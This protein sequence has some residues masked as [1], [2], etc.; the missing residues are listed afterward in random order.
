VEDERQGRHAGI[1]H[2][3]DGECLLVAVTDA[4]VALR[5]RYHHRAPVT[6]KNLLLGGDLPVRV[7]GGV[8]QPSR[9]G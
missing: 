6:A 4:M 3:A 1:R 7:L 9:R 5:K 8:Y 2:R